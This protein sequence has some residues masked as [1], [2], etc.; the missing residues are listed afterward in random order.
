MLLRISFFQRLPQTHFNL[1]ADLFCRI[2]DDS[3]EVAIITIHFFVIIIIL[4]V[5]IMSLDI[6]VIIVTIVAA[7]TISCYY[8]HY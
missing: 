5:I 7:V 1:N 8:N 3:I 4:V 6:I 2:L